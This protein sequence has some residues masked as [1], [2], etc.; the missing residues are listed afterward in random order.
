M[1]IDEHG[2]A[3]DPPDLHTGH[4][5]HSDPDSRLH[6]HRHPGPDSY[7]HRD[8]DGNPARVMPPVGKPT[9]LIR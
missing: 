5:D 9:Y 1:Y 3:D 4:D 6:C 2:R 7:C 8:G